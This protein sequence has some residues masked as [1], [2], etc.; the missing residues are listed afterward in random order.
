MTWQP[1]ARWVHSLRPGQ[2]P[3]FFP[4]GYDESELHEITCVGDQFAKFINSDGETVD[5]AEFAK[6]ADEQ[7]FEQH[8][9]DS[10]GFTIIELMIVI[11]IIGILTSVALQ[12][13]HEKGLCITNLT[14]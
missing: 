1:N 6:Q 7:R 13:L 12:A 14:C 8:L 2:A 4:V 9:H 5:C 11:A 3:T 10:H